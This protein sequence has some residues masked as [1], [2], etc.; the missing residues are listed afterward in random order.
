[1][2][3]DP[4]PKAHKPSPKINIWALA[5]SIP[6]LIAGARNR[7]QTPK[8]SMATAPQIHVSLSS[9]VFL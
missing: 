3:N 9:G 4:K 8:I 6:F 2:A 1:M 7:H 5:F